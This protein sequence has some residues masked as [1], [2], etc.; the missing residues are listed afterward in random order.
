M[1][2]LGNRE[3]SKQLK[4]P[5]PFGTPG[6]CLEKQWDP[7]ARTPGRT[8]G[9]PRASPSSADGPFSDLGVV[10]SGLQLPHG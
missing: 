10:L 1:H 5:S 6:S 2:F 4:T 8:S 3:L 7:V 9:D